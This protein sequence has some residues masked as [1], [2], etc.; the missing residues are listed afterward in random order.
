M[1][2]TIWNCLLLPLVEPDNLE[3]NIL[4]GNQTYNLIRLQMIRRR[5]K[6]TGV[7][8]VINVKTVYHMETIAFKD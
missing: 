2:V 3:F 6:Q 1:K 7:W 5:I 4:Y 8:G